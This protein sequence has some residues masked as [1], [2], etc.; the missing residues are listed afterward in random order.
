MT[1]AGKEYASAEHLPVLIAPG[2]VA[3]AEDRYWVFNSGHSFHEPELST[4]NYLLYPRLGD[5]AVL[6]VGAP[7]VEAQSATAAVVEEVVDFGLS[8]EMWRP[9]R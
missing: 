3:G 7:R 8:D 1:V 4:L 6:K 5:W 2:Q 9:I